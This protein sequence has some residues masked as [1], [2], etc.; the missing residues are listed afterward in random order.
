MRRVFVRCPSVPAT[1]PPALA[2]R[3]T[4]PTPSPPPPAPS[5][6]V[7]GALPRAHG[8]QLASRDEILWEYG[9]PILEV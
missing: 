2:C 7:P 1:P 5:P 6:G 4:T 9:I 8:L 3:A